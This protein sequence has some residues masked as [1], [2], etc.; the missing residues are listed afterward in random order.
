MRAQTILATLAAITLLACGTDDGDPPGGPGGAGGGGEAGGG[1]GGSGGTVEPGALGDPMEVLV[2]VGPTGSHYLMSRVLDETLVVCTGRFG[3]KTHD[4][5]DPASLTEL[6]TLNF[7]LGKRCEYLTID[8]AAKIAFVTHAQEQLNPQ[9]FLAAVN[10]S[11]PSEPKEIALQALDEQPAGLDRLDDLI[12]VAAKAD[13]LL[14]YDF[15]G[16][17]FT[18]A[19]SVPMS[20]AY[21]LRFVDKL[22]YVA[23]GSDG[24][25]IVDFTDPKN[26]QL[27]G[28]VDLDGIAKDLVI[29][30]G[31][32]YVALAGAGVATVDVSNPDAPKEL[33]TDQTPGSATAIAISPAVNGLFVADW[34]DI[35]IFDISNRDNPA[36]LGRE[37]LE[38]KKD[39]ESRSMGIASDGVNVYGSNWDILG[40]YEFVPGVSAPDLVI[41][42]SDLL[43]ADTAQGETTVAAVVLANDGPHP[44][45]SIS[46]NAADGL[47]VEFVPESIAPFGTAIMEVKYTAASSDPFDSAIS[48]TSNDIDQGT[49]TVNVF[50]NQ[51][52]LGVGDAVPDWSYFDLDQKPVSL[53]NYANQVVMLAYFSTF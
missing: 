13:G 40:S 18:P 43:L 30:G 42:P 49:Q 52:G 16:T 37:P 17:S 44:L 26:P 10:L 46:V 51:A 53:A 27:R 2:E 47:T 41:S 35:R 39:K 36:P 32:A 29:D 11:T 24:L 5:A 15:G 33:D 25:A 22:A 1:A 48:V 9:S 34:N 14:L 45:D 19:G 21:N 28:S 7:S 12:V 20:E 6:A 31:R 38:L 3:F 4:I 50:A 23:N 8:N